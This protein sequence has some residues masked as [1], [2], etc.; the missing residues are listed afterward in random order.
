MI[1]AATEREF[2]EAMRNLG[3][4]KIEFIKHEYRYCVYLPSDNI[5]WAK[6]YLWHRCSPGVSVEFVP[7][8]VIAG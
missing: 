6:E 3:C 7:D 8:D 1:M 2:K 4:S 5:K